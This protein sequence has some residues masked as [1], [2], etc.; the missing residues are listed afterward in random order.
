MR[1][2]RIQNGAMAILS[3]SC[4]RRGAD[5]N[6]QAELYG[7]ELCGNA[8]QGASHKGHGQIVQRLLD[9]GADVHAQDDV[10]SNAL[11]TASAGGHDQIVQRRLPKKGADVN[12]Q[13]GN[14]ANS[15]QAASQ[16]GHECIVQRDALERH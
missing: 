11:Q 13:G 14:Y 4:S 15:L 3:S 7:G 5:V 12:V 1:C 6:T 10:Y 9:A 16:W 8:L 2:V